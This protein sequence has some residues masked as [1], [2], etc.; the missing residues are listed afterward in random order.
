MFEKVICISIDSSNSPS[1]IS[2]MI[3]KEVGILR[4]YAVQHVPSFPPY[5]TSLLALKKI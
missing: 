5:N 3:G 2:N 4:A 1:S